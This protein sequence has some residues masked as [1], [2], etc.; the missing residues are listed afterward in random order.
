MLLAGVFILP[1]WLSKGSTAQPIPE[2]KYLNAPGF[3]PDLTDPATDGKPNEPPNEGE[4]CML[5][6]NRFD[7]E[8]S[9]RGAGIKRWLLKDPQFVGTEAEDMTTRPDHER[10]RSLR[11]LFRNGEANDQLEFD[12]FMWTKSQVSAKEC[13][14]EYAKE[15]LVRIEKTFKTGDAPYELLVETKV[16]NL[17]AEKKKHAF[18]IESFSYRKNEQTKGSFGR[19][20]PF[21]TE[22]VCGEK[23][24][25]R[26]AKE[27]FK[28]GWFVGKE[29]TT[30][31]AVSNYF[32]AQAVVPEIGSK[33][34]C[35]LL[36]EAWYASGQAPDDDK[37]GA[38]Y[39]AKLVYPNAELAPNQSTTYKQTAYFGPK[40]RSILSKAAEGRGLSNL[41]NLGFFSPVAQVL[42][43]I[44][45]FFHKHVTFGNWGLAIIFMTIALRLALFPLTWKSI[46]TTVKM[47]RLK[48]DLDALNVKFAD[49]PAGKNLAM[50]ELYRTKGVN[51]FGGCLPQLVQMPVWFAMFTTLQTAVELYH[52][53]FLY[54]KDLTDRDPYFILPLVLGACMILQQRIVP[55][56]GM[57]PM[58]QKMMMYFMPAL[59][60]FMMLF[61]P[62]GLALYS[63]TNSLFFIVQQLVVEY[64]FPRSKDE[65]I[66]VKTIPAGSE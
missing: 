42:V 60:T 45:V 47:R 64:F 21:T 1:K 33:A 11:T 57:D 6:G 16:T 40:D 15:G 3:N 12:R 20:S 2:E 24:V 25:V 41:I 63:L 55:Q 13:R 26:K 43:G 18:S 8:L 10:W 65:G 28:E 35:E 5:A 54:F 53:K 30:F 22:L 52:T 14:F 61:L 4:L 39:H 34:K 38:V 19:I 7:V 17:A 56:T 29:E 23:E 59:F 31:S 46:Q 36:A 62:A 44:L 49:D 51:P 48:P 32:F 66:V 50:M 27:D 58:Q 37:A 9:S